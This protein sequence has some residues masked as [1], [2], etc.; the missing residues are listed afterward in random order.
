MSSNQIDSHCLEFEWKLLKSGEFFTFDLLVESNID[1]TEDF[2]IDK[3]NFTYRIENSKQYL[4]TENYKLNEVK[5]NYKY[6]PILL[7]I[8][9][10][11]VSLGYLLKNDKKLSHYIY[12]D[13]T[14]Y[15]VNLNVKKDNSIVVE[16]KDYDIYYKFVDNAEL[17][18]QDITP[19]FKESNIARN[20]NII[21]GILYMII[22]IIVLIFWLLYLRKTRMLS[23]LNT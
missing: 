6:A 3:T 2:N 22:A 9:A 8:V 10:S 20:G 21:I 1:A 15:E 14:K 13:K 18:K 7:I 12:K 16:N 11:V 19:F 17:S 4:K 5:N 23:R